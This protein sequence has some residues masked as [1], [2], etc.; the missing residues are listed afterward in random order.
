M[1]FGGTSVGSAQRIKSI[2]RIVTDHLSK[3]EKVVVVVSAM[4]GVT[5]RLLACAKA[6]VMKDRVELDRNF[7][8]LYELHIRTVNELNFHKDEE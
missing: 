6:A 2:A 4:N 5:D 3:K 7:S 8:I 1:K